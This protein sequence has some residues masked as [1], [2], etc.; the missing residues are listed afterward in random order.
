M[1]LPV[2]V[3]IVLGLLVLVGIGLTL[4]DLL[5]ARV[6]PVS[7]VPAPVPLSPCELPP[8]SGPPG[9]TRDLTPADNRGD[10]RL[11]S[12]ELP[13]RTTIT[14][15]GRL[16]IETD[17]ELVIRG[18]IDLSHRFGGAPGAPWGLDLISRNGTVTIAAGARILGGEA[19]SGADSDRSGGFIRAQGGAGDSGSAIRLI[20]QAVVI[21]GEIVG[22]GGGDGGFAKAEATGAFGYVGSAGAAGGGGGHGGSVSIC[23]LEGIQ[24]APAARITAGAGGLGARGNAIA[25]N[26]NRAQAIGGR[27]GDAG[28]VRFAGFGDVSVPVIVLQGPAGQLPRVEAGRASAADTTRARGGSGSLGRGGGRGI[29]NGNDGGDGASVVFE[30]AFVR[31]QVPI[32]RIAQIFTA[33]DGQRGAGTVTIGG[34]GD[35][36]TV[37]SGAGGGDADGFAGYGGLPGAAPLIPVETPTGI[38]PLT[39]APGRPGSGGD[40]F[41]VRCGAGGNPGR[42]GGSFGVV[43]GDSGIATA[44]GGDNGAGTPPAPGGAPVVSTVAIGTATAGG[45]ASQV[46]QPGAP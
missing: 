6:Y 11:V 13:P 20:G 29:A 40:A 2:V 28:A 8:T 14:L 25:Q 12:A 33:S 15:T 22:D 30:N 35:D 24:L 21:E 10:V 7:L 4:R 41:A 38:V 36:G 3:L 1:T 46:R 45:A 23:A 5:G 18:T 27:G 19:P 17:N 16:R 44:R 31:S 32:G 26:S 37:F 34:D 39:G 43:G 9:A 42:L